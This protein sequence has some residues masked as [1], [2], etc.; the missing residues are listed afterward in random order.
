MQIEIE[1]V[2]KTSGEWGEEYGLPHKIVYTRHKNLGYRGKDLLKEPIKKNENPSG[3]TYI[4][5]VKRIGKWRLALPILESNIRKR[6]HIG[7][8]NT[9]EGAV[10]AKNEFYKDNDTKEHILV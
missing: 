2:K 6:K 5:W 3:H 4:T 9:I 1:G 10:K 8:F 7:Y